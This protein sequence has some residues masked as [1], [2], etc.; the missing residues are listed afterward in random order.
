M[1][2]E[3]VVGFINSGIAREKGSTD[4]GANNSRHWAYAIPVT[5]YLEHSKADP[6]Y[7]FSTLKIHTIF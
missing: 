5:T 7:L 6:N 4:N 2:M 3:I 1:E